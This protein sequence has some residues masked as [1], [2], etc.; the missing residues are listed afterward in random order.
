MEQRKKVLITNLYFQKFTGSELHVLEFAHL[1]K[2]KGYD[3]VIAVYKKSYPLLQELEEGITVI[4][5]QKE[6]LKEM[7]FEIV[8]IQH[9]PVFDYLVSRYGL[10]YKRMVVSK[11]SVINAM[12]NLPVCTQEAAFILCFKTVWKQSILKEAASMQDTKE[13]WI[14]SRSFPIISR[15][16][17]WSSRKRWAGI[18]R[19]I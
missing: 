16:S 3:V 5:C 15:R 8:F 7:E 19:W 14:R 9:F 6:A 4:E 12:E 10:K 17:F 18:I 1:F 2:E 11:L 13:R